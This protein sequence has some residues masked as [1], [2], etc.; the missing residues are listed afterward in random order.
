[1]TPPLANKFS[2]EESAD[3]VVCQK[4]QGG[5]VAALKDGDLVDRYPALVLLDVQHYPPHLHWK[6]MDELTVSQFP[7]PSGHTYTQLALRVEGA[8]PANPS[9]PLP[10]VQ[11]VHLNPTHLAGNPART[12]SAVYTVPIR[13]TVGSIN[14]GS[15]E[16]RIA[17]NP[18]STRLEG[19]FLNGGRGRL[20]Q[21]TNGEGVSLLD[22]VALLFLLLNSIQVLTHCVTVPAGYY[23]NQAFFLPNTSVFRPNGAGASA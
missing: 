14:P 13:G 2:T 23:M 15:L 6:E 12:S 22:G 16:V 18:I 10:Y 21:M 8:V 4:Q 5:V 19:T 7:A 1:V 9:L 20:A 11:N 17:G 3:Y